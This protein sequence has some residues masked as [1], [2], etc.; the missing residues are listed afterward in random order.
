[1]LLTVVLARAGAV[2]TCAGAV[3]EALTALGR[4]RPD[5]IV[6]D[7][8][9]PDEDGYSLIRRLRALRPERGGQIPALALTAYAGREDEARA[10]EA[11]FQLHLAKPVD[12]L[13]L[14]EAVARVSGWTRVV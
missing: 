10:L 3:R 13:R 2:V 12:P 4:A 1:E 5:V 14:V 6:S 9:M 11:G 7:I 8:S